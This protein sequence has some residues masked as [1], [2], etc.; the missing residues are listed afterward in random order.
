[1]TDTRAARVVIP[2]REQL[3]YHEWITFGDRVRANRLGVS[4]PRMMFADW[5]RWTCNNT[6]C[7]ALAFVSDAGVRTLIAAAE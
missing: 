1:L 2:H 7:P 3:D 6:E 5:T 4:N